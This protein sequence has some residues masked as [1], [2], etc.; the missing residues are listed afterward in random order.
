MKIY[1][2]K[3]KEIKSLKEKTFKLEKD[4][5]NLFEENLFQLVGGSR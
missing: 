5:Q 4:I 3:N 2:H 1:Q